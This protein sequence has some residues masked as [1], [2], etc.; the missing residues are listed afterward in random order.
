MKK[1]YKYDLTMIIG[2]KGTGKSTLLTKYAIK[3]NK[4]GWSVFSNTDIFNTYKLDPNNMAQYS[5]PINSLLLIDE[6]GIIW[7]NRKFKT[8]DDFTRDFFKYQRHEH[9]KIIMTSQTMDY[10]LKLKNLTDNVYQCINLFDVISINKRIYKKLG[11]PKKQDENTNESYLVDMY[12]YAPIW[13]WQFTYMPRYRMFFNS[14]YTNYRKPYPKIKY[15]HKNIKELY[16]YTKLHKY[17]SYR[18]K[19]FSK[20]LKMAYIRNKKSYKVKDEYIVASV[21]R[22]LRATNI[23]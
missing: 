14:Y 6:V 10:D 16:Q 19:S 22:P 7:D 1:K 18:I 12:H 17:I 4:M 5:F 2:N 20:A 3:Y 15:E 9:I 8:F 11:I 23:G 13:Q 21:L